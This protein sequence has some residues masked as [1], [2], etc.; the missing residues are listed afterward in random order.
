[1]ALA[2]E[3]RVL[4]RALTEDAT[5]A[6]IIDTV[7][8]FLQLRQTRRQALPDSAIGFEQGVEWLEGSARYADTQIMMLVGASDTTLSADGMAGAIEYP[9]A[10]VVWDDF[11]AQLDDL[12]SIPG[13]YRDRLYVLGAAQMFVLDR[14]VPNW[15]SQMFESGLPPETLLQEYLAQTPQ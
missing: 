6:Y 4:N 11:R 5:D 2:E 7:A 3:A 1:M 13:T 12:L 14:L 8:E 9:L 15:Q 10:A